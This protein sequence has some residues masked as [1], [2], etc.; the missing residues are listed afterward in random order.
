[1]M[2]LCWISGLSSNLRILYVLMVPK[3]SQR[4]ESKVVGGRIDVDIVT[5]VP[6]RY[7]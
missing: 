2:R 1:M 7:C 5:K 4:A 3:N 6:Y